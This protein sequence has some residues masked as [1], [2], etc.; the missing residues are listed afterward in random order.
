MTSL[1]QALANNIATEIANTIPPHV[2]AEQKRLARIR[3]VQDI[4]VR[5]FAKAKQ[6]FTDGIMNA[7]P[8]ASLQMQVG[9]K[10]FTIAPDY[11]LEIEDHIGWYY[12][13]K[14]HRFNGMGGHTWEVPAGLNDP[15]RF[16][17][18]WEDFKNWAASNDLNAVWKCG[19]G[20]CAGWWFLRVEPTTSA[21]QG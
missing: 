3:E 16:A 14:G 8:M 6:F 2:L 7:T 17:A 1:G 10:G 12:D 20:G 18:S 4:G 19:R 11:N 5:F 9:G 13:E 15:E 21:T